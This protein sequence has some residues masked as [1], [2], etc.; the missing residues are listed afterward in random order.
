MWSWSQ[1]CRW[2]RISICW[3]K[4]GCRYHF[5]NQCGINCS[6]YSIGNFCWCTRCCRS[7]DWFF[8]DRW[9]FTW[10]N[11]NWSRS[12]Q[13]GYFKLFCNTFLNPISTYLEKCTI[14][15]IFWFDEICL[16]CFRIIIQSE[17]CFQIAQLKCE[18]NNRLCFG[19]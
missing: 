14:N 17:I 11:S 2:V 13:Y 12:L 4:S 9:W 6:R 3:R 18:E 1:W 19:F 16:D 15:N 10:C 8:Q 5:R 7:L